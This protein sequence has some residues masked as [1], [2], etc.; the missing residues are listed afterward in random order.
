MR[1]CAPEREK[2]FLTRRFTDFSV[3]NSRMS[4]LRPRQQHMSHQFC[5]SL[6]EGHLCEGTMNRVHS[7]GTLLDA[8]ICLF[9]VET[10]SS[11]EKHGRRMLLS[12]RISDSEVQRRPP[13]RT[14]ADTQSY[15][16][17]TML[18]WKT[19]TFPQL[20]RTA[21]N[22]HLTYHQQCC[23]SRHLSPTHA[24]T[25]I[26]SDTQAQFVRH[27]PLSPTPIVNAHMRVI[28]MLMRHLSCSTCGP[29]S[30]A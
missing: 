16:I 30:N 1:S 7:H 27:S 29:A 12:V 15:S 18:D 5:N 23:A 8:M 9:A 24:R 20:A 25:C 4:L 21:L 28:T 3:R 6:R 14:D 10:R 17:S 22:V 11:Q 26:P 13:T 2:I 19:S